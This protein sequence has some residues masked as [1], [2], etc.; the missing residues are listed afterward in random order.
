MSG[1][2]RGVEKVAHPAKALHAQRA[3]ILQVKHIPVSVAFVDF[4][5][6]AL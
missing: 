1:S 6:E 3:R 4:Q 2:E 5:S